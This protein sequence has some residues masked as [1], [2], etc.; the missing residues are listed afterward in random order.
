MSGPAVH[1]TE[2]ALHDRR[3]GL[4]GWSIGVGLYVAM[5]AGMW[6]SIDASDKLKQ[7]LQDYPD[8]V[9]EFFG[10]GALDL[11]TPIGYVNAELFSL[12]V[13]L[14]LVVFAIGFG[15][16]T[17]A[18]EHERGVL[19]LTLVNPIRRRRVV[20]EKA[21][22]LIAGV[23]ALATVGA[24]VLAAVGAAVGLGLSAQGLAAAFTGAVLLCVLH[25]LIALLVGAATGSRG[26][27]I[28]AAAALFAGGYLLQALAGLVSWLEPARV[29]STFYLYNGSVPL[30]NGFP[31]VHYLVLAAL[32]VA[33]LAGS[34]VVFERRDLAG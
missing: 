32:S 16:S 22:A 1:V 27:A 4:T 10:G 23:V 6:Q 9:K 11:S 29:L 8:T 24:V 19:D 30:A 25:G 26:T 12:L 33:A 18:G 15:A 2:R 14:L 28:G 13:P 17:I 5:I 21:L 34:V 7:A 31:V 3:R 20:A